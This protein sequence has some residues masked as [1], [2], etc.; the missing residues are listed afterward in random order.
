V[1]QP[2]IY[3]EPYVASLF[4]YYHEDR[5][6]AAVTPPTPAWKT[7]DEAEHKGGGRAF[8]APPGDMFGA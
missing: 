6:L 2:G 5:P 1:R 7:D 4:R 8:V 3:K